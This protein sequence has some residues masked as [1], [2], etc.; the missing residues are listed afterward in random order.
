[1]EGLPAID[2][3][4]P[5]DAERCNRCPWIHGSAAEGLCESPLDWPGVHAARALIE[6]VPLEGHW[7]DR[8]REWMAERRHE[9][10][11][12]HDFATKGALKNNFPFSGSDLRQI[13]SIV[14]SKTAGLVAGLIRGFCE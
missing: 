14:G 9:E 2:A 7:F 8:T 1:M 13:R 3:R 11:E 6:G 5:P 10:F 12:A 4:I